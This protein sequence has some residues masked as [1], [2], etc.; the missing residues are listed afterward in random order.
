M[1]GNVLLTYMTQLFVSVRSW[2]FFTGAVDVG[3]VLWFGTFPFTGLMEP[4]KRLKKAAHC[5]CE[6][7]FRRLRPEWHELHAVLEKPPAHESKADRQRPNAA[8]HV[9]RIGATTL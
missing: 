5:H 4:M 7:D 9:Q 1:G 3:S 2:A 8:Q 6:E